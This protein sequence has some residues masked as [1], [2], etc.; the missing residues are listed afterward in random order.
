MAHFE[1]TI[2]EETIFK[3]RIFTVKQKQVILENGKQQTREVVE[4]NGGAS[5]LPIDADGNIYLIKQFRIA[6]ES[7]TLEIPAGKL[8]KGEDPFEAAKRELKEET[9]F[10]AKHYISLG[11]T[12]PTVG[13]CGEKIYIYIATG[14][15][16]GETHPDEDE[17]VSTYKY[18]FKEAYEM[19]M[20]GTIKDGK[21]LVAILK[22]KEL[23]GD[24]LM[25]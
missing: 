3:G 2:S 17:F 5:V 11:E 19:C 9:G 15:E 25:K 16:S 8:E 13:Y 21:T 23:L 1:K 24:E 14:L 6:F 20:D 12:W 22:A 7:E 4:H 18:S 10:T